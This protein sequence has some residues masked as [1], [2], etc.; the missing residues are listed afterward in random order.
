M[1]F[2]DTNALLTLQEEAF[3]EPFAI[4]QVT[5]HELEH[6]KTDSRK[7]NEV[8]YK[9]R[10][11]TRLLSDPKVRYVSVDYSNVCEVATSTEKF[12]NKTPCCNDYLICHDA[13]VFGCN[14]K[15]HVFV[16]DDISCANI[17]KN[18]YGLNVE[19]LKT[20]DDN[21]TGYKEIV[22]SEEEQA[23]L[24]EGLEENKYD[25]LV[26]EYLIGF[27]DDG[28]VVD[29]WIWDGSKYTVVKKQNM[30][31]KYFGDVKPFKG[32]A[33]Q[34][35]A[36]DSMFRN[37]LT[38]LCGPAGTGKSYLAI[39][40]LLK[41][42]EAGKIDRII[43]FCN[44]VSTKN[45]ARLGFL[46]GTRDEKL[47]ES[48]IGV[49]LAAKLGGEYVVEEMIND[50]KL[51]IL[52]MCD[53]RGFDTKDMNAAVYITEA[54]NMDVELMRLAL[55]RVGEDTIVIIDGDH[56]AQVDMTEFAGTSNGM[57]RMSKVFR[58]DPSYGEIKL[59]NIHRS[60]IAELAQ[61]M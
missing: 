14:G 21:Y 16:T 43:V 20:E 3:S 42:L 33:Y 13:M 27:D 9:A 18:I 41:M 37:K 11:I 15:N 7:T 38:M 5:L 22:L 59:K 2:Y 55:Q 47:M 56:E 57:K 23:A 26:N 32:D 34:Q 31:S 60:H 40:F 6:I 52:P 44:T 17:A 1:K 25:C 19:R 61:K 48:S 53:I 28:N 51:S 10:N 50:R 30:K 45:A 8:K 35:L 58:G 39:G 46:P 49:M 29:K 24:Y 36:I 4:S 54:Q 12:L